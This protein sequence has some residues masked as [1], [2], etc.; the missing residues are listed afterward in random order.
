MPLRLAE[1][2]LDL[3]RGAADH[4][5]SRL[6]RH[7]RVSRLRS[8]RRQTLRVGGGVRLF[9]GSLDG[10]RRG[11]VRGKV[12]RRSGAPVAVPHRRPRRSQPRRRNVHF[13]GFPIGRRGARRVAG[14]RTRL[15]A[16]RPGHRVTDHDREFLRRFPSGR[17]G[18]RAF[19]R[20]QHDG[21]R[22]GD[23]VSRRRVLRRRRKRRQ[24]QLGVLGPNV[25][26]AVPSRRR[27]STV[28]DPRR[29][30]G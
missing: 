9:R 14:R 19:R 8:Q 5:F 29:S 23:R 20:R 25:R 18:R 11:D 26:D 28:G 13:R 3:P 6:P 24:P 21:A 27:V 7:L 16:L 22:R 10:G 2:C 12:D 4:R 30:L 15:P 17:R 1:R